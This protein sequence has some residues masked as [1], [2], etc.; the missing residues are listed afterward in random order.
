MPEP[1][2]R[3]IVVEAETTEAAARL[4][5]DHP[6]IRIFPGDGIN[7]MPFLT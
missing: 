1:F 5:E 4:F 2:S 6:H 3:H 7:I